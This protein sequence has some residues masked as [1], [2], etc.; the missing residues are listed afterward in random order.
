MPNSSRHT[1]HTCA[2]ARAHPAGK[3]APLPP[4]IINAFSATLRG[5]QYVVNASLTAGSLTL[6]KGTPK[7][8]PSGLEVTFTSA[9]GTSCTFRPPST[10]IAAGET[11]TYV[12]QACAPCTNYIKKTLGLAPGAALSVAVRARQS[13]VFAASEVWSYTFNTTLL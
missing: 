2:H 8:A 10:K 13:G 11:R 12:N 5:S 4:V 7:G 3:N 9:N 1:R 6:I